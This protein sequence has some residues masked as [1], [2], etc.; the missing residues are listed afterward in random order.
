[1]TFDRIVNAA[2]VIAAAVALMLALASLT[3]IGA[4]EAKTAPVFTGIVKGVAVGGYD[5]VAYHT[6]GKAVVGSKAI[7]LQ[8]E[9][10]EWRFASEAN[11]AAFQAAPHT[12]APQYG[13][14][15]AWAVSE[16]YT[17]KGDPQAWSIVGGKLYLNYNKP[18]QST[19]EKDATKRIV[20][21][22]ARWPG[23]LAK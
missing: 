16:G 14:Y 8:H 9:G 11:R 7:T 21:G 18:T 4:A 3:V 17:A 15:C 19:W 2:A 12:F 22:D 6:E 1:M 23:L 10:A 13:G 5:A 20:K